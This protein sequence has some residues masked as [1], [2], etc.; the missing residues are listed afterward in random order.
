[1]LLLRW[2]FDQRKDDEKLR[3]VADSPQW[4][5]IDNKFL[6]FDKE[7]RNIRFGLSSD[8]IN[9]FRNMRSRYSTWLVLLWL[10][11][12][13]P[14]KTKDAI[15]ARKDMVLLGIRL[16]LAPVE[17]DKKRTYLPPACYTMSKAEKTQFYKCLH[18][19]K[20]PSSYSAN[21]KSLVSMKDYKLQGIKSPDCH[22]LMAHM[23]PIAI[24]EGSIVEGYASE[25]VIDFYTKYLEGVKGISVPQ[26]RHVGRL[27]R[28]GKRHILGV[29]NVVDEDEYDQFDELSPF[30]EGI[31][32][33]DGENTYLRFDHD[34]GLWVDTAGA[35][36]RA[37]GIG[38]CAVCC[39]RAASEAAFFHVCYSSCIIE[40]LICLAH[41]V[42]FVEMGDDVLARH[43]IGQSLWLGMLSGLV[44]GLVEQSVTSE[45]VKPELTQEKR[46]KER[47]D[48]LICKPK[49]FQDSMKRF[50]KFENKNISIVAP[51]DM[52]SKDWQEWIE[53]DAVLDLHIN[54]KVDISL[55]HWWA[56]GAGGHW[57][58]FVVCQNLRKGYILDSSKKT[59]NE[60][61]YY[62]PEMVERAF[63]IK[64]D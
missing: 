34:E 39:E 44:T 6:K 9:P 29:D 13:I 59:N 63:K 36:R 27:H 16:E 42:I 14:G 43:D 20:V 51:R 49:I 60:K 4:R 10:L 8:G 62:F 15:N 12:N 48:I 46:V 35:K 55:I 23:I 58:L 38:V 7:I 56:I 40:N 11:S 1:M 19:I 53:Y 31:P 41:I 54:A 64:F 3:H 22:V 61:K 47:L 21:I 26:S 28:F 5:K 2:H 33:I 45:P 30:S 25:E 32:P 17:N 37:F 57:L 24:R 50:M 52:Y 18:D